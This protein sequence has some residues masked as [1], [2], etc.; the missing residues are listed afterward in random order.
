[1]TYEDQWSTPER[2][3]LRD[4]VTAFVKKEVTPNLPQWERDCEIPR[5]L[6]KKIAHAGFLGAGVPEEVGGDGGNLIDQ[7]SVVEAWI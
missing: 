3:A 1:M 5:E 2:K 4:T 6:Q 7:V